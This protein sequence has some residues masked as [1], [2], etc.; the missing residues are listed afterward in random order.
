MAL[1]MYFFIDMA[2]RDSINFKHKYGT[3]LF[4]LQ[5]GEIVGR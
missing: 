5:L 3:E 2:V 1:N 4:G